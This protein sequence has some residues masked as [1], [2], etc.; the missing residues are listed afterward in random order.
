MTNL[1]QADKFHNLHQAR[2]VSAV[3]LF[4]SMLL[5]ILTRYSIFKVAEE[6][7]SFLK[8]IL[9][10]YSFLVNKQTL[11]AICKRTFHIVFSLERYK[12][13]KA[14]GHERSDIIFMLHN[15]SIVL[16]FP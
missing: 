5:Y 7:Q 9:Y 11:L 13:E 1:H 2:G 15:D 16:G 4:H 3:Y 10:L 14:W 8:R 6:G 12:S